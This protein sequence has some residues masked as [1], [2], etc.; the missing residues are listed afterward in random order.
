MAQKLGLNFIKFSKGFIERPSSLEKYRVNT[1]DFTRKRKLSFVDL[2]LCLTRLLRRNIQ[3]ELN[4]YFAQNHLYPEGVSITS[5][6]FVQT[7]KKMKQEMFYDLN[8]GIVEEFYTDND[9]TVQLY[10]GHR[11]LAI[12]GSTIQLPVNA[13][14]IKAYGSFKNQHQINDVVLGRVSILYDV[15]NDIVLDGVLKPYK[16]SEIALA[17]GHYSL[18][19]END[20]IIMDRG[21]PAFDSI[22]ELQSRKIH[23]LYRCKINFSKQIAAFYHSKSKDAIIEIAPNRGILQKDKPYTKE[24]T[25][26]VRLL[27][28]ELPSGEVEILMTS[29]LDGTIYP[30]KD[31]KELYAM[32]W[33]VETYYNR[34]KNIIGVERFSGTSDQFIQQEFN[35]ALYMSNMQSILT[36]D[37]QF[38]ADQKYENRKYEYKINASMS[39]SLL[40][41]YL[42]QLFTSGKED[43][44]IMKEF[45]NL[46]VK[47][48]IPIRP[49]R[50]FERNHKYRK[51]I[52]PKQ[53]RNR[54]II[55]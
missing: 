14:T 33:S 38:E 18:A 43:E 13:N 34:F 11:L 6:A 3:L 40:R 49:N 9:E 51:R 44:E 4:S 2:S 50:S 48:V 5:S 26:K 32:R 20:I 36:K 21:Y 16:E 19:K 30:Y 12:D 15:L 22:Y 52:R 25:I 10:K 31:F 29:L 17:R 8:Q 42:I 28:I 37:A 39:L 27:R 46:L 41:E 7:R 1:V 47:N 35:C 23:F 54:K 55:L 24:T 45:K 53:F